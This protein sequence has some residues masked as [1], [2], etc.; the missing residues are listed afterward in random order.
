MHCHPR[1]P[2]CLSCWPE[3]PFNLSVL[4]LLLLKLPTLPA[5]LSRLRASGMSGT[6]TDLGYGAPAAHVP[7]RRGT[8]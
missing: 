6:G 3:P 8:V 7:G 2:I 1:R 4:R 5:L